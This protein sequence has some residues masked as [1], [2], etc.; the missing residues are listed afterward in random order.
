MGN[1]HYR[2]YHISREESLEVVKKMRML[3]E[4]DVVIVP[5]DK[6]FN[7]FDVWGFSTFME[8]G[9]SAPVILKKSLILL[10]RDVGIQSGAFNQPLE[11][12]C[13]SLP[14]KV[15]EKVAGNIYQEANSILHR[16]KVLGYLPKDKELKNIE[17][18]L[19][20]V[21]FAVKEKVHP[22]SKIYSVSKEQLNMPD[23]AWHLFST[24]GSTSMFKD[25]SIVRPSSLPTILTAR[26]ELLNHP[27][28]QEDGDILKGAKVFAET[29][30]KLNRA[31]T[32]HEELTYE[33]LKSVFKAVK[34]G[35]NVSVLYYIEQALN[36]AVGDTKQFFKRFKEAQEFTSKLEQ[37]K[38]VKSIKPII[39][40]GSPYF[41]VD[42]D[43]DNIEYSVQSGSRYIYK[44]FSQ[45]RGVM[46]VEQG[47]ETSLYRVTLN[48]LMD[49]ANSEDFD[50]RYVK[51]EEGEWVKVFKSGQKLSFKFTPAFVDSIERTRHLEILEYNDNRTGTNMLG[52]ALPLWGVNVFEEGKIYDNVDRFHEDLLSLKQKVDP[53][54][55]VSYM[56]KVWEQGYAV[57]NGN[58]EKL[59]EY[60][61]VAKEIRRISKSLEP[62]VVKAVNAKFDTNYQSIKGIKDMDFGLDSGFSYIEYA[63]AGKREEAEEYQHHFS[64][65][66]INPHNAVTFIPRVQS[67]T[68]KGF[69][70]KTFV[71]ELNKHLPKEYQLY[72]H[73]ALD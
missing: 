40:K 15:W 57:R 13:Q 37:Y 24:S 52:D 2:K 14:K 19:S 53:N 44:P 45:S 17:R 70:G 8:R 18:I 1:S 38:A 39:H 23:E 20:H 3:E 47:E 21:E 48:V 73:E 31:K 43:L 26:E 65:E 7:R 68:I 49:I 62:A 63:D 33:G 16:I 5:T 67:L 60:K 64:E 12:L 59:E 29:L 6:E 30:T 58:T 72:Y 51:Y 22:L 61:R 25:G 34:R 27:S 66:M 28:V 71:S 41:L 69:V 9:G 55:R 56:L 46:L 4:R 36:N 10:L 42:G 50:Y 54:E 35:K 11:I 32:S